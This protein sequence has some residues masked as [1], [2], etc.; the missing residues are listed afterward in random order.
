MKALA[1]G[2]AL[3]VALFAMA[4]GETVVVEKEVIKTIEVPGQT[5]TTEVIKEVQVRPSPSPK[6]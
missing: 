1:F 5:V 6:R 3:F 4:C 2:A